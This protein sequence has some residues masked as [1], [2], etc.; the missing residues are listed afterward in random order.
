MS[1]L[2]A[3]ASGIP[4]VATAVGGTPEL[5]DHGR[6]GILVPPDDAAALADALS[7]LLQDPAGRHALTSAARQR[8][9]DRYSE[10]AMLRAY[11]ALYRGDVPEPATPHEP[12]TAVRQCVA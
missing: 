10:L 5:L 1:V 8:V 2:E 11:E 12:H 6:C 7:R 4:V 9:L 3:M